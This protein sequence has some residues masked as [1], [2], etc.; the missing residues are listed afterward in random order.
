MALVYPEL[1]ELQCNRC[2]NLVLNDEISMKL[3][4]ELKH[5]GG[6]VAFYPPEPALMGLPKAGGV[7]SA[8]E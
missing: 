2:K 6:I 3:H 7:R 5:G 4:V 8:E 1:L